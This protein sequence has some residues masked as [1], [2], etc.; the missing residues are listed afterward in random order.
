MCTIFLSYKMHKDYPFIYLGNR[1]EFKGR[2]TARGVLEDGILMGKDL[3]K[4]G[5]WMGITDQGRFCCLT[6]YRDMQDTRTYDTS[7]GHLT[8][9][10][11]QGKITLKNF[12]SHLHETK[13][14]Y[15]GYNL[16]FGSLNCLYYY[17][18]TKDMLKPLKPGIYGLSNAF[19]DSPWPKVKR[20]KVALESALSIA[21]DPLTLFSILDNRSYAQ[22]TELPSTGLKL[23]DERALSAIH[24]DHGQYGTVVKQLMLIGRNGEA[25]YYEKNIKDDF[26]TIYKTIFKVGDGNDC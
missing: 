5:T 10:W 20:G 16:I 7:R 19:L 25:K 9:K 6:N 24:V 18:N 4:G 12:T 15:K 3:D 26:H 8:L 17:S 22:S 11:L 13:D 1:D 23:T 14:D 2:P 21:I